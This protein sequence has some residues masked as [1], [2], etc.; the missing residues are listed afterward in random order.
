MCYC[1]GWDP[2]GCE[3]AGS[4][5][6]ELA[7]ERDRTGE[8][9]SLIL[10][11][12]GDPVAVAEICWAEAYLNLWV[13]DDAG[14]R[15]AQIETH[16]LGDRLAVRSVRQWE[17]EPED[18]EFA[19][20][21]LIRWR[22]ISTP[23]GRSSE[24]IVHDEYLEDGEQVGSGEWIF[25]ADASTVDAPVFGRWDAL[26][27]LA[28]FLDPAPE[29]W[30]V[31]RD[32]SD[33]HGR[34]LP[35]AQRPWQPPSAPQ[36]VWLD[37]IIT[38]GSPG[39]DEYG[40]PMTVELEQIGVLRMPTGQLMVHSPVYDNSQH[41]LTVTVLPGE[42][43]VVASGDLAVSLIVLD[44]PVASW[45][46]ATQPGD[47]PWMLEPDQ[48]F[49]FGGDINAGCFYDGGTPIHKFAKSAVQDGQWQ[50]DPAIGGD[51][52]FEHPATDANLIA[53][54]LPSD[55]GFPVWVGRTADGRLARF[56]ADTRPFPDVFVP[57][58]RE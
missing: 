25:G 17:Y 34:G 4:L 47:E 35:P 24:W 48:S 14:D 13:F 52:V 46:P 20:E 40:D 58:A 26:A 36:P 45:E 2:L 6:P 8:Q 38:D 1:E 55:G 41:P 28:A 53:F 22:R 31:V 10:T 37:E 57:E 43:P 50:W 32:L 54:D 49:G 11:R 51:P 39:S 7:E 3:P 27:A 15:V 21:A 5:S 44:E 42:Y 12:V 23:A 19:D 29:P 18:A 56:V 16:R 9:Y 30:Q 33:P